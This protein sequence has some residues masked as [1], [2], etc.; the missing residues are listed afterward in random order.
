MVQ[1]AGEVTSLLPGP[2]RP[3]VAAV[4]DAIA[5]HPVFAG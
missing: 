1:T 3:V 2:G 5:V 4:L